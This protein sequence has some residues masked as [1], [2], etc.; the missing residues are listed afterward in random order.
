MSLESGV[1][2]QEQG[3]PREGKDE[4]ARNGYRYKTAAVVAVLFFAAL[5][6]LVRAATPAAGVERTLQ[7]YASAISAQDLAA[8]ERTVV[9][10][11][12]LSVFE[13]TRPPL[14]PDRGWAAYRDD[15][16][17]PEFEVAITTNY[18]IDDVRTHVGGNMAYA[19]FNYSIRMLGQ[20]PGS[21]ARTLGGHGFGT[22]V[23]VRREGAWR[24]QHLHTTAVEMGMLD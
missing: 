15:H 12:E 19:T 8:V 20:L 22:A 17:V 2:R 9:P 7:A 4:S 10:T 3:R 24:I 11:N 5:L 21:R 23:L 18:A 14:Q 16:L 6:P 13:Y 1:D